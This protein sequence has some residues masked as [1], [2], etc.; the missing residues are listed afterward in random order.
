[1][2]RAARLPLSPGDTPFRSGSPT[3]LLDPRL[4]NL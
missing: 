3:K 2:T 4:G 1:M